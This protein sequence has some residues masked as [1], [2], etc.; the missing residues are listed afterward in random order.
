ML[1]TEQALQRIKEL[2][3]QIEQIKMDYGQQLQE[4]DQR[5]RELVDSLIKE[6]ETV[7]EMLNNTRKELNELKSNA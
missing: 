1:D 2:E 5:N 4:K 3:D 6:N 7:A